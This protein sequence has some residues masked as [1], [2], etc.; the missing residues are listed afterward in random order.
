MRRA[1][2]AAVVSAGVVLPLAACSSSTSTPSAAPT[3]SAP[4]TTTSASSA[5]CNL[6]T[7]RDVI[8]RYVTPSL[9]P[10]AQVVGDVDLALCETTFDSLARTTSTDPGF[11]T[12][13]AFASDN[14]DYNADAVP[15][16]PLKKVQAQAGA[17]C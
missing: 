12:T 9:P 6:K 2:I 16:A 7:Q 14:P 15:A 13:A 11:C 17:A 10:S 8:L 4:D 1:L 5:A 3:T